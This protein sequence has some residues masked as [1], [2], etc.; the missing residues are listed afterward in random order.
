V[1]PQ[2]SEQI[3]ERVANATG[4]W[5]RKLGVPILLENGPIYFQMPGSTM[6]QF[7]F[8]QTLCARSSSQLL[9]LDL[10]HLVITCS[11]AQLDPLAAI[12]SLP[13]DRVV[14]IHL[15][16]T[17]AQSGV[18]WDDHAEPISDVVFD[19]LKY[20]LRT[21]SPSAVTVEYNWDSQF[22]RRSLEKDINRVRQLVTDAEQAIS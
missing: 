2:L 9:L 13:L 8:M 20:V 16:G 15:S 11:N 6:S 1:S 21:S 19:L 3:L 17:K 22:P 10:A 18:L 5:Q 12:Q 14:E 7:A 4:S